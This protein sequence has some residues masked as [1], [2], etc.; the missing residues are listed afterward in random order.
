MRSEA[1]GRLSELSQY[2]WG[3]VTTS[4]TA[5]L[6]VRR[7]ELHRL[8]ADGALEAIGFGVYRI[9]GAPA[10]PLLDLRVAWLQLAPSKAV[11]ERV[12]AEG[13][14]SHTS[15]AQLYGV[16][17]FEPDAYEFT[18][19]YRRRTRRQDLR[20]HRAAV[21]DEEVD[22][23]DQL[24]VTRPGRLARDLLEARYDGVHIGQVMADLLDRRLAKRAE[25]I[26]AAAPAA[27]AYGMPAGD[28][29][30][31]VDGLVESATGHP[32]LHR[33]TARRQP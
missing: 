20:L 4:Q 13:V 32:A 25:L 10:V 29:V 6:G 8:V 2:Q 26:R 19:P 1:L 33:R 15:A 11:E 12:V 28:G 16:G 31:L 9:S 21:T 22:W 23:L 7:W 18:V 3:L 27:A 5:H 24:P 30:A 17:D 14:V